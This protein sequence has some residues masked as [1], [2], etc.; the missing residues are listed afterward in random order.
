M[1]GDMPR[2]AWP[3]A[4]LLAALAAQAC[5]ARAAEPAGPAR[6]A[7]AGPSG[8]ADGVPGAADA[9]AGASTS[10]ADA[11]ADAGLDEMGAAACDA[12]VA[13]FLACPGVPEDSKV[14]L[15]AAAR[16]WHEDAETSPDARARVA[17]GC[18]E[19]AHMTE[20]MLLQLGC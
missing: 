17:A 9:G 13:R 4:L 8:E 2:A 19:I 12:V 11:G 1:I 16:R 18:L 3:C 7:A 6:A 20:E 14:Q 15:A 10:I 5:G